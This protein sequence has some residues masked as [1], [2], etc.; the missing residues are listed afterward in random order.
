M[1]FN[2]CTFCTYFEGIN[3]C[4]G[5][6]ARIQK[7]PVIVFR[8]VGIVERCCWAL[9][10]SVFAERYWWAF[11]H[12]HYKVGI[13]PPSRAHIYP[14]HVTFALARYHIKI[15]VEGD[16]KTKAG[17]KRK[18]HKLSVSAF[19]TCVSWGM[20]L[21]LWG[22]GIG[23]LLVH[24]GLR[25]SLQFI[26]QPFLE[27]VRYGRHILCLIPSLVA[28]KVLLMIHITECTECQVFCPV[29]RIGSHRPL[30]LLASECCFPAFGPV[31]R[32]TRL[33]GRGWGDSIRIGRLAMQYA[34]TVVLS[35]LSTSFAYEFVH[36]MKLW[37]SNTATKFFKP[38]T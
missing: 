28:V 22:S 17:S 20:F 4:R 33:W 2:R 35:T 36:C 34:E 18:V 16:T 30:T 7:L 25:M 38:Q 24:K 13:L 12:E 23:V 15:Y 21:N 31:G 3:A 1:F 11:V 29:V 8:S 5:W 6:K 19:G 10:V 9:F 37:F 32:H 27:I 14:L 26:N